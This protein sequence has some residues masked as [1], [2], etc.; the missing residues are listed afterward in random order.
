MIRRDGKP[1]W[2][3]SAKAHGL[4]EQDTLKATCITTSQGSRLDTTLAIPVQD[5]SLPVEDIMVS[6]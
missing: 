4:T 2:L 1:I 3:G 6:K 5:M